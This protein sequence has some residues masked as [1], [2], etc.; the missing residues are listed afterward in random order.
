MRCRGGKREEKKNES[1]PSQGKKEKKKS[2]TVRPL[3]AAAIT[4]K[5]KG[6]ATA[7]VLAFR[8]LHQCPETERGEKK[9]RGLRK[10]RCMRLLRR[11]GKKRGKKGG[12]YR[13]ITRLEPQLLLQWHLQ[14]GG[15]KRKVE[16]LRVRP[17]RPARER[18][19]KKPRQRGAGKSNSRRS[20]STKKKKKR[21]VADDASI[22][23]ALARDRRKKEERGGRPR[24]T[25]RPCGGGK[26]KK[27]KKRK[28]HCFNVRF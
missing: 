28:M 11:G 27:K 13:P 8:R 6:G 19:K 7:T 5:E 9:K 3:G 16:C 24:R 23:S 20:L 1:M 17:P 26:K 10:N 18:R 25:G 22:S 15:E 21:Y 2:E 14:G 12:A 4:K